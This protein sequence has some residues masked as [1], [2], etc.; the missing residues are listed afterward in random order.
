ML[1][2]NALNSLLYWTYLHVEHWHASED[3]LW[4]MPITSVEK[5]HYYHTNIIFI[6]QYVYVS[7]VV[8]QLYFTT[9][10]LEHLN[11]TKCSH[12]HLCRCM[13][14]RNTEYVGESNI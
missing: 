6:N 4:K 3:A 2:I 12:W 1:T 13:Y 8:T 5:A 7:I 14:G 10:M 11:N 9:N